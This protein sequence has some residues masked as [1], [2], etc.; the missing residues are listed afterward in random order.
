MIILSERDMEQIKKKLAALKAEKDDALERLEEA[1]AKC[2]Q[3]TQ[4]A[5]S[6][7]VITS[8]RL[9]QIFSYV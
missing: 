9:V 1:E 5:D 7:S 4:R 6:V 8:R 2:L 3:A